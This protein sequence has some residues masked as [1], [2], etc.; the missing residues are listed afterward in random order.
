MCRRSAC[1]WR[2]GANGLETT[3]PRYA[4]SL[5]AVS[6][7]AGPITASTR[8]RATAVIRLIDQYD[9]DPQRVSFLGLGTES[10][11]DNSAGAIIIKGMVD[12][13]LQASGPAAHRTKLRSP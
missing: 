2:T 9:I 5:G 7:S 11:T 3:G 6:A 8:W 4:R 1:G 10:S 13:A 12:Q